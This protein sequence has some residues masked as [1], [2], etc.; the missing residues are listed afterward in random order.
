MTAAVV[1][2]SHSPLIGK[3]DPEPEVLNRVAAAVDAAKA[4]IS[5]FAPELVVSRFL[6]APFFSG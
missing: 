6:D 1:G 3:N 5:D 2:L 4:F